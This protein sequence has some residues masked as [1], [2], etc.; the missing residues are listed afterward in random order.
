MALSFQ[1]C[2]KPTL[3]V[4][5]EVQLIDRVTKDLAA[6]AVPVL[7]R[8]GRYR[9]MRLK[10]ELT[11]AMVEINTDVCE[12]VGQAGE[13]LARQLDRLQDIAA[14]MGLRIAVSG[15]HPF[16]DWRE[17][18]IFPDERHMGLL[19]KFQWLARR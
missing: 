4:E 15:T 6:A 9:E 3:G 12:T 19:E 17:R 18:K 14:A 11:V 7:K 10:S 2:P 1:N 13:D 16:Q 8:A 5:V